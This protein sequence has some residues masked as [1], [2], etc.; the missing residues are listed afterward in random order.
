MNY[1]LTILRQRL[2]G[3]IHENDILEI[4][5]ATQGTDGNAAKLTLYRLL[6]DNNKRIAENAAWIFTHFDL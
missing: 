1:T 2:S 3:K 5:H 6:F 4:C